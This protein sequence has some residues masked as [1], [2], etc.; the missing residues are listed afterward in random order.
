ML[1]PAWSLAVPGAS[2]LALAG[3]YNL[4]F[5]VRGERASSPP[6]RAAT[7]PSAACDGGAKQ[8]PEQSG[9]DSEERAVMID[10]VRDPAF[11]AH[12]TK[13]AFASQG[14]GGPA[15]QLPE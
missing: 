6:P 10:V 5:L 13:R 9:A 12:T 2:T 4:V 7:A 14:A 3:A 11:E 1:A 8:L 15:R